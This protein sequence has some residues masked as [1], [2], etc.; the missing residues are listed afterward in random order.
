MEANERSLMICWWSSCNPICSQCQIGSCQDHVNSARVALGWGWA[1]G[2]KE[3]VANQMMSEV[4]FP[5]CLLRML[6]IKLFCF[7]IRLL[8][9]CTSVLSRELKIKKGYPTLE[10]T[11]RCKNSACRMTSGWQA[12]ASFFVT[13]GIISRAEDTILVGGAGVY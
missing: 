2:T 11:F 5:I 13:G 10:N 3:A 1:G 6:K 8:F 12:M 4:H 7:E 9:V